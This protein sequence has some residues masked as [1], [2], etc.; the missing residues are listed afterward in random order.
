MHLFGTSGMKASDRWGCGRGGQSDNLY[1]GQAKLWEL[2]APSKKLA[3]LCFT[4]E[5]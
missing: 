2:G 5:R 4:C 1:K 3:P